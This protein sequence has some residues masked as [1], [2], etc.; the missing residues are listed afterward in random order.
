MGCISSHFFLLILHRLQPPLEYTRGMFAERLVSKLVAEI[1]YKSFT[2]EANNLTSIVDHEQRSCRKCSQRCTACILMCLVMHDDLTSFKP[3]PQKSHTRDEEC[4][5]RVPISVRKVL[6]GCWWRCSELGGLPAQY[7][8]D[9]MRTDEKLWKALQSTG[10]EVPF[11]FSM[12][13]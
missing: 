4:V 7:G 2:P 1:W 9:S 11:C 8:S 10:F 5:Q 6:G 12:F 13:G 3:R